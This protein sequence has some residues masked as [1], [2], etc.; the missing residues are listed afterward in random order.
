MSTYHGMPPAETN[1]KVLATWSTERQL[2]N[3][4]RRLEHDFVNV[5]RRCQQQWQDVNDF[6]NGYVFRFVKHPRALEVFSQTGNLIIKTKIENG[7]AAVLYDA[8]APHIDG[9]EFKG[10]VN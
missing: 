2:R 6:S 7:M 5:T 10:Q 9:Y 1:Q 8:L 3:E 4:C